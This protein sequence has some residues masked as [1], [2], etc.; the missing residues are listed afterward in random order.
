MLIVSLD[1]NHLHVLARFPDHNPRHWI[2]LAKR[3][4]SHSVRQQGLRTDE[5]GLWAKRSRAEPITSRRHQVRTVGSRLDHVNRGA[6]ME[7]RSGRASQA[8][9]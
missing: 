1:A 4:A 9:K 8:G 2:G 3:H 5:G 7:I 6:G